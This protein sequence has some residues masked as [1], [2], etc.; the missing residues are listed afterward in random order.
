MERTGHRNLGGN[1][2]KE[3]SYTIGKAYRDNFS[4]DEFIASAI[5]ISRDQL[6]E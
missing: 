5:L 2:C 1:G 4:I 6:L 3:K